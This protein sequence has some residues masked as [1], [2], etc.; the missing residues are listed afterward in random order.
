MVDDLTGNRIVFNGEIYNFRELR[1]QLSEQGHRFRTSSDTE[2]LLG[3]YAEYGL[4][5]VSRLRG[6]FAFAIWDPKRGRLVLARDP[7]GIKP[8]YFAER[9]STLR[10]ASEVRTLLATGAV[11]TSPSPAGHVGFLLW[12]SVPEPHTLYRGVQSL[13]AGEIVC[14][15]HGGITR[16]RASA[17]V[18]PDPA[19]PVP[20]LADLV[21]DSVRA[22]LV[23]DVPVGLFLSS[24]IDSG[25]ICGHAVEQGY[26]LRTLTVTFDDY[27]SRDHDESPL[28]ERVAKLYGTRHQTIRMAHEEFDRMVEKALT[29]MD[30]PSVDGVNTYVISG[31]ARA[32]GLKVALSGLGADEVFAGYSTFSDMGRLRKWFGPL[33]HLPELGRGIRIAT[34]AVLRRRQPK[35]AGLIE[36]SGTDEGAYLLL[37][38]LFMPWEISRIV[39]ADFARAGWEELCG[40]GGV[41]DLAVGRLLRQRT[42]SMEVGR[43][44]R[45]QLLRDTD[46]A[47]MA[48]GLEVRVPYVDTRLMR[49]VDWRLAAGL[50][51]EKADLARTPRRP[52]PDEVVSRA[53]TG[54][55]VPLDAWARRNCPSTTPLT[56]YGRRAFALFVYRSFTRSPFGNP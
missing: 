18:P 52:L 4:E 10:F 22:H 33:S 3:L 51:V 14:I 5:M 16:G 15:D 50:A 11:D 46:W 27:A 20:E 41:R 32:A 2:V 25:T 34:A 13:R 35:L 36:Y 49:G 24:G 54:F 56:A 44:M 7:L 17:P 38:G 31:V 45:N 29:A 21:A 53:R 47:S 9:D 1:A 43:Y 37:R 30:Q 19:P 12:G 48:H 39:D 23:S 28:A 26:D 42:S 40:L 8:L 55:D 6:M